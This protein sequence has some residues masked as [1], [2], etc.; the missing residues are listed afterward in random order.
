MVKDIMRTIE[1]RTTKEEVE[2]NVGRL[3]SIDSLLR[4]MEEDFGMQDLICKKLREVSKMLS[5]RTVTSVSEMLNVNCFPILESVI[6]LRPED[7]KRDH[8]SFDFDYTKENTI[9]PELLKYRKGDNTALRRLSEVSDSIVFHTLLFFH[10]KDSFYSVD[11]RVREERLSAYQ[12]LIDNMPLSQDAYRLLEHIKRWEIYDSFVTNGSK[13]CRT[14]PPFTEK[15]V[16]DL[17]I[18]SWETSSIGNR[19]IFVDNQVQMPDGDVLDILAV[20]KETGQDVIIEIKVDGRNPYKQLRSYN[21]HFDNKAKMVAL[22]IS[23]V[24]NKK[25]GIEYLTFKDVMD[26][27]TYRTLTSESPSNA[28]S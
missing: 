27:K 6:S 24:V 4:N 22:T 14:K 8:G 20:D 23:E 16:E 1:D 3:L 12:F 15:Q 18:Q 5:N 9:R 11:E 7:W 21:F 17:L 28:T 10:G 19:Y 26:S 2:V 25:D 13:Y